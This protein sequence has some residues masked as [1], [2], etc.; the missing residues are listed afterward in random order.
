MKIG[1]VNIR[2][3]KSVPS[4]G[5]NVDALLDKILLEAE[6]LDLKANPDRAANGTIIEATLDKGRGF[7]ATILVQNGT[8]SKVTCWF[9]ASIMVRVKAMHNERNQKIEVAPPSTP[10]LILGLKWCATGR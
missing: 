1:V 4:S 8:L 6:L 7:V 3:R 5:L 2:A 10:V 9:P